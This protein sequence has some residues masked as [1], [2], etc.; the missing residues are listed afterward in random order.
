MA[1]SLCSWLCSLNITAHI[2]ITHHYMTKANGNRRCSISA[3]FQLLEIIKGWMEEWESVLKVA[4]EGRR[5]GRRVRGLRHR[6]SSHLTSSFNEALI[7]SHGGGVRDPCL[8]SKG[9]PLTL[10]DTRACR[11]N[12][13]RTWMHRLSDGGM[14]KCMDGWAE[15]ESSKGSAS[16]SCGQKPG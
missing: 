13:G 8:H 7:I 3:G 14:Q 9:M 10:H 1:D 6:P 15:D 5:A 2:N 4:C 12:P 11:E 16:R